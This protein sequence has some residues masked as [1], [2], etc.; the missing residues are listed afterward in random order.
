[1]GRTEAGEVLQRA[2]TP[3]QTPQERLATAIAFQE[4]LIRRSDPE[5]SLHIDAALAK[6]DG[7][8]WVQPVDEAGQPV[9]SP[10]SYS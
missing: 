3:G 1:M 7:I 5:E 2:E 9:P 6:L 4:G 8:D 10:H